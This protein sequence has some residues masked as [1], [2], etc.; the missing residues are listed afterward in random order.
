[1]RA[2]VVWLY[3]IEWP[4]CLFLHSRASTVPTDCPTLRVVLPC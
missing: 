1:M 2:L 3:L 4:R